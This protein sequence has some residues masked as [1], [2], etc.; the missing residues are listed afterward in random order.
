MES[1]GNGQLRRV[2]GRPALSGA[3]PPIGNELRAADF[4]GGRG[5]LDVFNITNS[6]ASETITRTT[7]TNYLR[8][9]AILAPI[10]ARVGFRL[11]W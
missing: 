11:L 7:G 2:V 9:A 4:R 6:S 3:A 5:F 10:T 1:E 8:P